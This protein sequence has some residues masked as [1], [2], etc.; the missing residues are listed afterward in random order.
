MGHTRQMAAGMVLGAFLAFGATVHA[1]KLG[2]VK[3][4][5]CEFAVMA[6]SIWPNGEPHSEVKPSALVVDFEGI[7]PQ[8]GLA[9][10]LI[11]GT[12]TVEILARMAGENL[13]LIHMFG[14]D[15]GKLYLTTVFTKESRPGHWIAVHSRHQ[16]RQSQLTFYSATPEHYTGECEPR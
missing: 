4:L 6:T 14:E 2:S 16:F 3:R 8:E 9:K 12:R 10:V 11:D 13:H 5:H 15:E 7:D 1:Q